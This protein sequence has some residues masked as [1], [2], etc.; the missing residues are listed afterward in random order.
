MEIRFAKYHVLI[1]GTLVAITLTSCTAATL[2]VAPETDPP[3]ATH[4]GASW[5]TAYALLDDALA[6]ADSGDEVWV[7]AGEYWPDD[8][9]LP[10]GMKLYGGFAGTETVRSQRDCRQYVALLHTTIFWVIDDTEGLCVVDGFTIDSDGSDGI[11]L[12]NSDS[13]VSNNTWTNSACNIVCWGGAPEIKGNR[14]F[15][16]VYG[17]VCKGAS[18]EYTI[19]L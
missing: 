8:I 18:A 17:V 5:S 2:R 10:V 4:D 9:L 13:I 1:L 3:R 12:E 19:T 16:Y 6:V 11:Y 15:G 7:A 14:L